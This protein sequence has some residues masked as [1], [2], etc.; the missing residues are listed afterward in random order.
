MT[1]PTMSGHRQRRPPS[2][3]PAAVAARDP[4]RNAPS[5]WQ[6]SLC[7]F[8]VSSSVPMRKGPHI[9]IGAA[10]TSPQFCSEPAPAPP[11]PPPG[12]PAPKPGGLGHVH[13]GGRR[14]RGGGGVGARLGMQSA[15]LVFCCAVTARTGGTSGRSQ[16]S[17][18]A[19]GGEGGGEGTRLSGAGG[20]GAGVRRRCRVRRPRYRARAR[21]SSS[22]VEDAMTDAADRK[23]VV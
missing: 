17:R 2:P 18:P 8:G 19:A 5:V 14:Y 7:G 4:L 22:S 23:S 3:A 10:S 20:A 12:V 9:I 16:G 1:S 15:R 11:P 13:S 21:A 6:H